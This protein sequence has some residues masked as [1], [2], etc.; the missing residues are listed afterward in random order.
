MEDFLTRISNYSP[1]RLALL[2]DD[3]QRRVAALE[4]AAHAPIAIIGMAC[5]LPGGADTA[6]HFWDLLARGEDAVTE[7][8]AERWNIDD[9]YDPDPD[10]P[11]KMSSRWGGFVR[12]ADRF[13]A[14]FFGISAREAQR[15]DPQHRLLL[16]VAWEALEHAGVNADRLTQ[17]HTGVYVGMSSVDYL[18][19]MRSG[20]LSSF[21]AYTASGAAH[22]IASGRLSYLLGTRGPS[23]SIDTACSSSLVAI[24]QA[25]NSLRRSESNLALAGGVNLILR[26]DVTVALSKAHM[27]APDGRCKPFDARANGFVRSEGCGMLVLKRLADA[28]ADGDPILAVIRGSASNQDGRSNG[29]TA[30]NGVAQEAVVRAALADAGATEQ[31]VQ[32][33]ETHGTGTSLGDPI[34]V[35]ALAAVFGA[36]R[37]ADSP[38]LIGSVKANLGHL[39]SAAGVAAVIKTV[40]A[41]QHGVVPAQLHFLEPNPYIPWDEMQVRVPRVATPWPAPATHDAARLA[42][43]SSFGFSGTN[44]H[45]VLASAPK[46]NAA[47]AALERPRHLLT[48][49]ARGDEAR[50]ALVTAYRAELSRPEA[51]LADIAFTANAGRAALTHRS[52]V[53]AASKE[54]AVARLDELASNAIANAGALTG[55]VPPRAPRIAFL[56]TGQGAQYAGMA[57]SLY[58]SQPRFRRALDECAGLLEGRLA[59]PL[60][61]VL[62][63]PDPARS[64]IHDTAYTQPALFAVEYALAQLWQS[65]GVQPMAVLGHSVGEYV[66]A[67]VAGVLTVEDALKLVVER[68]RLMGALPRNGAMASLAADEAQVKSLI[69]PWQSEVAIAA[70]NG[71]HAVV[72]SGRDSAVAAIL[73]RAA[74]SG[75]SATPLTVS[76]AFH[77]PLIEPMLAEFGR[78]AE[79]VSY[80]TASIDVISNVT[81]ERMD[82]RA[83]DGPYWRDHARSA[84]Q[85][86]RSMHSLAQ[87]GCDTFLEVGPHPTLLALARQSL[88]DGALTWLPS[89]RR[90]VDDWAQILESLA[91]LHIRGA[92]VDWAEFDAGYARRKVVLPS[93]PFQRERF[94]VD[95][96]A[97]G[98]EAEPRVEARASADPVADLMHEIVWRDGPTPGGALPTPAVVRSIVSPRI[99][100]IATDNGLGAYESFSVALDRL[101]AQYILKALQTLGANLQ[102]GELVQTEALAERL[103]VIARHRR[104]F[105]R[106]LQILAEDGFLVAEPQGFRVARALVAG[107]P[108]AEAQRLHEQHSDGAAE[109]TITSRCA[110]ELGPVLRGQTDPLPLLFPEGS[111]ADMER[112]YRMSPPARTY[113]QLI[114]EAVVALAR[115]RSGA[116]PLRILEIGG[117]TG[118]TT[119]FVLPLLR[120]DEVEYTFT[121]LSPLFLNRAREKFGERGCM[122]FAVLDIAADLEAQGFSRASFDV[123]IGANVVHATPDIAVSLVQARSLLAPGGQIILLE[124]TTPQRFGDLT[125]GLLEGWWAFTDLTRRKYALMPREAW[126]RVLSEAGFA[127]SAVIVDADAGP[128][129]TQQAIFVA[130]APLAEHAHQVARW[131]IVPDTGGAAGSL[132]AALRAS[133][134]EALVLGPG[135]GT[136]GRALADAERSGAR[137]SGVIHLSA[138]DAV[139]DQETSPEALWAGQE[140]LVQSALDTVHTLAAA[141]ATS[142]PPPLWLVTRGAQATQEAE[143]S[144]PAQA[145]LWGLSHVVAIEHPGLACRRVDLDAS[146]SFAASLPALL[147]ELRAPSREDQVAL[148]GERRLLRR[149]SKRITRSGTKKPK[150]GPDRT[151]L[152]TGG[153]R[154]LGLRVA[155]WLVQQGAN[156][157]VL[158]SR[159]APDAAAEATLRGLRAQGARVLAITG[160]VS[161]EADVRRVLDEITRSL[162]ALSGIV[163]A[164]G[165]LDD[166]ALSAQSWPRF[167]T[168]MAPKVLGTWLL[169]RLTGPLDF[170][171]LFSSGAAIAGS[172][173]QANHAAANAFEDAFA[174]YR[175]AR[176]QPT[177]SINWGP[178]A[179]VGAAADRQVSGPSFVTQIAP[180]D[181]LRAL[182]A[183]LES[184]ASRPRLAT[185][186]VVAIAAD[187]S[188][189]ALAPLAWRE[190]P[191]F[192][193]LSPAIGGAARPTAAEHAESEV[194]LRDRLLAIAPNRR[195]AALQD[196]VRTLTVKVLGVQHSAT[197]DLHEPLRQLGLDSLMA[198]ELRNLLA[199]AVGQPMPATITFD[200]PSVAALAEFFASEALADI[201]HPVLAGIA[202]P[203]PSRAPEPTAVDDD[204]SSAELASQLADRLDRLFSE[205]PK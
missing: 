22:S 175:Q 5:R 158:M 111:L 40:L 194:A 196:H 32:F 127:S 178:W 2:A 141:E 132:S 92:P 153:L 202:S 78:Y 71:P 72:I 76:H 94:W 197:F 48:I 123:I 164:A 31:E 54:E 113:N 199:K 98:A 47:V 25:V 67:C 97:G 191:L 13:D 115:S 192:R 148:R 58:E 137:F 26:P 171:A 33:V 46:R 177:V 11:G 82:S 1:K 172:A 163:H 44:V 84:V 126:A 91:K 116:A 73:E 93:Y 170:F 150:I 52:V 23:M 161:R 155:E 124:G 55:V 204:L 189:L 149:L 138:L 187:W 130:Q 147:R 65:W 203:E 62:Y 87:L 128:V 95:V 35:Q 156:C 64:P 144:N 36:G 83:F 43:V 142:S 19:V 16:E 154:G 50:R 51:S 75:V 69:A 104:L 102:P 185:S 152:I 105:A 201:M 24:H 186:Q 99:A 42:G 8:P 101:T 181:G 20:G 136:M 59:Q 200:H 34:E 74:L 85:F 80:R 190:A 15:M 3:L 193:E 195:L 109:L 86:T 179:E 151:Y 133:G 6:A 121:D 103:G 53:I 139:L 14:H 49:S 81:G 173:G 183:A 108:D 27:M 143:L 167:A 77:S 38:L 114:A 110:R 182:A 79:S 168:V 100:Q 70:V 135:L 129:L 180:K 157:L 21:D 134:D 107:D 120:D 7:V 118:S 146:V 119:A 96:P 61:S 140:R 29:L 176:G 66:A 68:G 125:V 63:P 117:G 56:F 184:D 18:Q 169:H 122:R 160:D 12:G 165:V 88:S 41:L 198:V 205:E 174:W 145:P 162:P 4:F 57:R 112:L 37:A 106:M 30:P 159:R 90:G 28:E 188:E 45:L 89:L 9:Y 131:L 39:E 17:T 10:A 166:G 60:L